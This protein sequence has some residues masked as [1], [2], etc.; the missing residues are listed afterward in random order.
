MRYF[1]LRLAAAA[2]FLGATLAAR[3][4]AWIQA[5]TSTPQAE[6]RDRARVVLAHALPKLDGDH[7]KTTL[8]EVNYGPGESS[9]PHS[10]PCPV[11]GYVV[12]GALRAQVQGEP[13]AIYKAGDSFYEPPGGLH[14]VSANASTTQPATFMAYFVCDREAPLST[15]VPEHIH[16]GGR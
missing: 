4:F 1:L 9:P 8:V 3:P 14:L 13:E 12:E 6:K 5:P 7:L 15:H 16:S 2:A 10:H 11:V